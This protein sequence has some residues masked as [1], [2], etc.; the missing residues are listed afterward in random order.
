MGFFMSLQVCFAGNPNQPI[1]AAESVS[2][3]EIDQDQ[4]C[5]KTLS[6]KFLY[7]HFEQN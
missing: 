1:T 7:L 2:G 6:C 4:I 3:V 5:L